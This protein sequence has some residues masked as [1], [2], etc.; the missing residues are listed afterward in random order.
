MPRIIKPKVLLEVR[1]LQVEFNSEQGKIHALDGIDFTLNEGE[2]L[3]LV[4]ESG[5]GKSTTAHSILRLIPAE[6]GRITNGEIIFNDSDLLKLSRNEIRKI[7]GNGISMIFQ[8]PSTSLNPVISIGNQI[9]ETIRL[10]TSLG[11][12]QASEHAITMLEQVGI[13]DPKSSMNLYPHQLSG[14]MQQRVMIAIAMACSPQLLIADEPTTSL[15]VT[16]QAQILDLMQNLVRNFNTSLILITHDLGVIARY[17]DKVAVM[18]AGK[19]IEIGSTEEV[20]LKSLHPYT[21]GLINSIPRLDTTQKDLLKPID[22]S[23]PSMLEIPKGCRFSDR[24]EFTYEKCYT[25][26]PPMNTTNINSAAHQA[27]C[28]RSKELGKLS[29]ISKK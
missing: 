10:H 11:K 4:G 9:T 16:I 6:D 8:E 26:E 5:C 22:G 3:G 28:W 23:P 12:N 20:F 13:A 24:C 15:D 19:I 7:R 29:S 27:S 17:T 21:L 1:N 18:Y 2:V 25:Q 14:G